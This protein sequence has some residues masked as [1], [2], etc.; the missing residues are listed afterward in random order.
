MLDFLLFWR[1]Y[2]ILL[3]QRGKKGP[4]KKSKRT[5]KLVQ[6]IQQELF[7]QMGS[8]YPSALKCLWDWTKDALT[9]GQ[10]LSFEL[11]EEVFGITKKWATYSYRIYTPCALDGKCQGLSFLFLW[12]K[13]IFF[14]FLNCLL[15]EWWSF[16]S[17]V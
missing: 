7:V 9:I 8:N 5:Y 12:S 11:T 16:L 15:L 6:D 4:L 2:F 3:F 1:V 14:I 17:E 13:R 10:T